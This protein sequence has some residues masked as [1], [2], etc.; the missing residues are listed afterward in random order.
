M[1]SDTGQTQKDS[2]HSSRKRR[3]SSRKSRNRKSGLLYKRLLSLLLLPLFVG[4]TMKSFQLLSAA[5]IDGQ[6]RNYL[7]FWQERFNKDKEQFTLSE[8]AV[9]IARAGAVRAADLVPNSPKYQE[10][11]GKIEAW[12]V[13]QAQRNGSVIESSHYQKGLAA[14]REAIRLRPA[15]PNVWADMAMTKVRAGEFDKEFFDTLRMAAKFGPWE[16][17]VMNTVTQLGLWYRNWLPADLKATVDDTIAR[18]AENY[19]HQAMTIARLQDKREVICPLV[20]K[21]EWFRK[22]CPSV[23]DGQS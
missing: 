13:L 7:A 17:G 3:S 9:A 4:L 18:Y 12:V 20:S 2:R 16:E 5:V 6:T 11:I 19:P 1:L 15:W 23:I 21:P 8:D 10:V 14:Y 22:D